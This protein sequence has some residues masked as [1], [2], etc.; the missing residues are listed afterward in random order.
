MSKFLPILF[1]ILL[2]LG[3]VLIAV[4]THNYGAAATGTYSLL[5]SLLATHGMA[6]AGVG[7]VF[8]AAVVH[9]KITSAS[10]AAVPEVIQP[11][12]GDRNKLCDLLWQ[13]AGVDAT[14][15]E[16]SAIKTLRAAKK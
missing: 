12:G 13:N 7:S 3:P 9:S 1:H 4:A 11:D 5:T 15:D 2:G 16:I 8:G 6:L 10:A 14:A